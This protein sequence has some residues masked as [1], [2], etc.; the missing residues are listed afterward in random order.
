MEILDIAHGSDE[1][2]EDD[3]NEVEEMGDSIETK[4][5]T[6]EVINA[7]STLRRFCLAEIGETDYCYATFE[8]IEN[9]IFF[10]VFCATNKQKLRIF[11]YNNDFNF[12]YVILFLYMSLLI[13][14]LLHLSRL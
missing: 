8:K 1:V 2:D 5:T 14:I 11:S 12:N 6:A 10:K 9:A 13:V 3:A 4:V 7:I